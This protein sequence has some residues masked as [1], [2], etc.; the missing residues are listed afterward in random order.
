MLSKPKSRAVAR[1]QLGDVDVER[2]QIANR[3]AVFGAVQPMHDV[4][5]RACSCPARRD[6]ASRRASVVKPTYSASVGCGMPCGGI[7]RTL[8][9]RSTR[10]H[11]AACGSRSSRLAV[12]RF[13]GSLA[14]CGLRLLWQPT[15]YCFS[16]ARCFAAS[17][18]DGRRRCA[19]G[20]ARGAAAAPALARSAP[21]A[22][23]AAPTAP[24]APTAR[25]ARG[26]DPDERRADQDLLHCVVLVRLLLVLLLSRSAAA[27][28][29]RGAG[30]FGPSPISSRTAAITSSRVSRLRPIRARVGVVARRRRRLGLLGQQQ[31]RQVVLVTASSFAPAATSARMIATCRAVHRLMQRRRRRPAPWRSG[32]RRRRAAP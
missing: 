7:A 2:Q 8:S 6:R 27:A 24:A 17:A 20:A 18:G 21:T 1:Q 30:S 10:S 29:A 19:A 11:V 32:S 12:S 28:A 3:V 16:Q 22:R 23:C 13:T 31:R 9:L 15:Q 25:A 4:A 26:A 5:A 14:G